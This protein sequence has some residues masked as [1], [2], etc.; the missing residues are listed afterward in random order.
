MKFKEIITALLSVA[1]PYLKKLIE[2]KVVPILVRKS[3]ELFD[4]RA[5]NVIKKLTKLLEKIKTTED[6][7]K[8]QR[9]LEGFKLGVNTIEVIGRKLV[10]AGGV[11]KGELKI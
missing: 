5:N 7:E 3:Y 4:K 2:S 8:K 6:T 9:H 1:I 11:L 10:E